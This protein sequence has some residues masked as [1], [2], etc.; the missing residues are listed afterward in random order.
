MADNEQLEQNKPDSLDLGLFVNNQYVTVKKI[1]VGGFGTVWQAYDFS[2]RNFIA[3]KEL[4]PEYAESKF[5]EMF[6]KEALIAKNIIH[7]NIVRVQHF[8]QGS[9]GSFYVVLD[10][11]RGVDLE[12]LIKRCNGMKIVIP[13]KLATLI[14]MNVLKAIDY[15]N[16]IARDSITGNSYGI[17]Y[18][19]I[20]PGNV[21]LSFD[22]NVKLSDFG[23]AKTADEIK[24]SIPQKVITGKYPYMSPEQI[25]GASDIDHRTDIFSVAV[26]YYEMLTGQ[27]LY[28]GS[29]EEI[30][31]QVLGAK[32]EPS[33]LYSPTMPAEIGDIIA[34]ALEK[35]KDKRYDRAI[36]MYRD[37]R[38]V[39]KG[40]ETDELTVELSD[41]I[42]K[43][44]RDVM[45]KSEKMI[46]NVKNLNIQDIEKNNR[47]PKVRCNDFIVGQSNASSSSQISQV[48]NNEQFTSSQN[49]SQSQVRQSVTSEA[50]KP[51]SEA[52]G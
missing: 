18:R 21:L 49:I 11:V 47:I 41:F 32:F 34:K 4:L 27:Q 31:A 6:Y 9:N 3:I 38:R 43:I 39:L 44:M 24:D 14:C 30:K 50:S 35:D 29:N 10:Y 13:W 16:R 48:D 25:K 7:D 52:K 8:W 23:I 40:V 26:L 17:V 5:V 42:L 51:Q 15:A 28:Q 46:E 12:T 20:S 37:I 1:G 22:G 36:E 19:D 33:Q 2:L 45:L